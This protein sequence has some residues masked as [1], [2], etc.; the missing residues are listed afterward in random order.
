MS[1]SHSHRASIATS[2]TRGP[3]CSHCASR[4]HRHRAS[5]ATVERSSRPSN[6]ASLDP[7]AI[8]HR[9]RPR[10]AGDAR[11]GTRRLDPT[12]IEHRSRR[13]QRTK[14]QLPSWKSRSHSHRA[15]I[16]TQAPQRSAR[17]RRRVSIPQSSSIDRDAVDSIRVADPRIVSIPQSSSIDRDA[18]AA[19]ARGVSS[20]ASRSHSHRASIATAPKE[21]KRRKHMLSRSHSHRASIATA[22]SPEGTDT[23]TS[24]RSHSHRASIAT[25]RS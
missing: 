10:R 17:G 4:S 23:V 18:G 1:R 12:A 2:W 16:A 13:G 3:S 15:S 9:S 5:I 25:G 20:L 22:V 7:T 24:S 6:G 11:A 19:S 14:G 21:N 8:E